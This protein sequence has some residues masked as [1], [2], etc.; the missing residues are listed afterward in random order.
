METTAGVTLQLLGPG[1]E[2]VV[3]SL[4]TYRALTDDEAR[5]F[6]ADD[7]TLMLVARD[8]DACVGF[9]LGYVLRR[10][11][12]DALQLFV[13]ELDVAES[14]R[15]R[16]IGTALMRELGR[17]ARGHGVRRG[18]VLTSA[19]NEP[20]MALYRSLGGERNDEE[21]VVWRFRYEGAWRRCARRRRTT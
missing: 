12:G 1:D 7:R 20:A 14:H 18:F 11:H 21:D 2:D 9:V 3:L 5:Q 15:R 19:S 13:Y 6:L 16:G 4:A 8:G 17:L 10:R